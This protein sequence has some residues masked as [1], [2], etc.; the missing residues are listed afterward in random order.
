MTKELEPDDGMLVTFMKTYGRD[1][2]ALTTILIFWFTIAQPELASR[3]IDYEE[4]KAIVNQMREIASTL[5]R[6]GVM[7]ERV[8]SGLT[9]LEAA[10][11]RE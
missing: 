9:R 6:T 1:A 4:Q 2:F 7:N 8:V 11:G 10:S 5:E 3:R